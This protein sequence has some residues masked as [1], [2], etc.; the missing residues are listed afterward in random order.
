MARGQGSNGSAARG[1]TMTEYLQFTCDVCRAIYQA[2]CIETAT[3]Q[4]SDGAQYYCCVE[5]LNNGEFESWQQPQPATR[6]AVWTGG[7]WDYEP[8]ANNATSAPTTPE[9]APE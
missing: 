2:E 6:R 5:C 4:G 3:T 1:E 7:A 8:I 9:N